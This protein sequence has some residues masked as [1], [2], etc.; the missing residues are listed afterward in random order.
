MTQ[1]TETVQE[2]KLLHGAAVT[3]ELVKVGRNPLASAQPTWTCVR[4]ESY[5][6]AHR[7]PSAQPEAIAPSRLDLP[8]ESFT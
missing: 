3:T 5:A 6:M 7:F 8:T 1:D 4:K 2:L